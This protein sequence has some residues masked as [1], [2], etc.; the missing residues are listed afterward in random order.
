MTIITD[1]ITNG[2][3]VRPIREEVPLYYATDDIQIF[4]DQGET[5]T[6]PFDFGTDA[7]ERMSCLLYTS[8]SPRD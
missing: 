5:R 1:V 7:I 8:P 3:E 2:L 6:R 4:I